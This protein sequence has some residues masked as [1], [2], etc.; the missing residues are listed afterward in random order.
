[1]MAGKGLEVQRTEI[2]CAALHI[3]GI[4]LSLVAK[5]STRFGC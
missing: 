3:Q 1:M 5:I 2:Y 4:N